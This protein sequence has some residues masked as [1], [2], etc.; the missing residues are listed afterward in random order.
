MRT[1]DG[2]GTEHLYG[3]EVFTYCS[4]VLYLC[5]DVPTDYTLI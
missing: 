4:K 2:C 1:C 3:C 5:W